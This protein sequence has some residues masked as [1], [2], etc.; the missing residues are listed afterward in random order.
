MKNTDEIIQDIKANYSR[1]VSADLEI[2][3]AR[4][5]L[6][7]CLFLALVCFYFVTGCAAQQRQTQGV[8]IGVVA[9]VANRA[10]PVLVAAYRAD[11]ERAIDA[12]TT[13]D[14][15]RLAL[16]VVR[17]RWAPVWVAWERTSEAQ[18]A[19]AALLE[20][21]EQPSPAKLEE[22]RGA[23]L[24]AYCGLRASAPTASLPEVP[25]LP[26]PTGGAP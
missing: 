18:G 25:G 9:Q 20:A 4:I 19:Y 15:A 11:G 8:A 24:G 7:L 21:Q 13:A 16:V 1:S 10:L 3:D 23:L 26:C 17:H 22:A 14:G 12:A 5:K 6:A 2:V